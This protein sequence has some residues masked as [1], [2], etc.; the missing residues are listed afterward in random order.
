VTAP[1]A[2]TPRIPRERRPQAILLAL[3][4]LV[5]AALTAAVVLRQ[6]PKCTK[7]SAAIAGAKEFR[8]PPCMFINKRALYFATLHTGLGDV[9]LELNPGLA[10]HT[11][12]NFVFLSL[13]GFYDGTTFHRV[14]NAADHALVQ[15]GDPTGTGQG[16]PGYTYAGERPSPIL[17]YARGILAMA[18]TGNLDST[19]SQFFI[20]VREW[21]ALGNPKAVPNYTFFGAVRDPASLAV[22]DRIVR[23]NVVGT[24]PVTPV[25][26][27]SVSVVVSNKDGTTSEVP[28][29]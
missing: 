6:P 24:R 3:L 13:T 14:E 29:P 26:I 20:M 9:K 27:E 8:A 19:G 23:V 2:S 12:N 18:N 17:R 10:E 4:V 28:R 21:A 15:A 7:L 5:F 11:V 1:A 22:L 25:T 16:G